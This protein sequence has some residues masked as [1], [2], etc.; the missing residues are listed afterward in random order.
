MTLKME[1]IEKTEMR[2]DMSKVKYHSICGKLSGSR[3]VLGSYLAGLTRHN[4]RSSS[5]TIRV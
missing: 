2:E 1:K 3:A 5:S 4:L